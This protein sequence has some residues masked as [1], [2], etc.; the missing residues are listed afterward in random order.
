MGATGIG[1]CRTEHMFLGERRALV[2]RA[3]LADDAPERAAASKALREPQRADF[4][5]LLEA[6]D[7]L[8]VTMRLLDPPLPRDRRREAEPARPAH[9]LPHRHRDDAPAALARLKETA[10][11]GG[12]VFH[13]LMDAV[14]VCSLGQI[15]AAFFE[16]GGQ[17][18]RN[19]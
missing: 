11:S 8:P 10:T 12:N 9:R 6:M 14:R 17:S 19:V 5:A 15:S 4:V 13:A 16:V 18:R 1:L 7:G 2:E 3:I